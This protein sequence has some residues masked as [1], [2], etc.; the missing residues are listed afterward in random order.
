MSDY[1]PKAVFMKQQKN[2][3]DFDCVFSF[4]SCLFVVLLNYVSHSADNR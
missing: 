4:I 2:A 3:A 1:I